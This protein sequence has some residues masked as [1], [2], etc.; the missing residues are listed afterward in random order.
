MKIV[1]LFIGIVFLL[2]SASGF[3]Q[4]N[5]EK[6]TPH[7][8][9]ELPWG[10][11]LMEFGYMQ[12]GP[13]NGE[14]MRWGPSSFAVHEKQIYVFD[15]IQQKVKVFDMRGEMVKHFPVDVRG[16]VMIAVDDEGNVWVNDGYEYNLKKYDNEGVL[17]EKIVYG[18]FPM[19]INTTLFIRNGE[20]FQRGCK[21][22]TRGIIQNHGEKGE[23]VYRGEKKKLNFAS[24]IHSIGEYTGKQYRERRENGKTIVTFTEKSGVS[25]DHVFETSYRDVVFFLSEDKGRNVYLLL[26]KGVGEGKTSSRIR[27]IY[28]YNKDHKLISVI[29]PLENQNFT[30]VLESRIVDDDGNIFHLTT[31]PHGKKVTMWSK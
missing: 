6:Y 21:I 19:P 20:L 11:G 22:L 29:G 13:V 31:H 2:A 24:H 28:K 4:E 8:I 15:S 12:D 26:S 1:H 5:M 27:H 14:G 25:H 30:D 16:D 3:A 10:N 17:R 18:A 23:R 9:F 7:V